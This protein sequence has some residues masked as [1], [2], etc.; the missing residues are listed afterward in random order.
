M[1]VFFCFVTSDAIVAFDGDVN[2]VTLSCK[3]SQPQPYEKDRV[4]IENLSSFLSFMSM[5]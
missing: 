5:V 4:L 3:Q 1:G 2:G